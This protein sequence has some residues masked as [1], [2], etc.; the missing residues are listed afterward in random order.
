MGWLNFQRKST[1]EVFENKIS[2]EKRILQNINNEL[3]LV[4]SQVD[5]MMDNLEGIDNLTS[6]MTQHVAQLEALLVKFSALSKRLD[7]DVH[8]HDNSTYAKVSALFTE[9]TELEEVANNWVEKDVGEIYLL[10]Q[11]INN[12]IKA[13]NVIK[14]ERNTIKKRARDLK[15]KNK[16][17][18]NEILKIHAQVSSGRSGTVKDSLDRK[19]SQSRRRMAGKQNKASG[20]GLARDIR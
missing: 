13:V 19:G 1:T 2:A 10:D 9:I 18:R 14:N 7:E 3:E 20:A 6:E 8:S 17:L 4:R 15:E 16:W 5:P 11:K 12:M